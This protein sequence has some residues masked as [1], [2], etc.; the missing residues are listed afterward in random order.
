MLAVELDSCWLFR[1]TVGWHVGTVVA[2][3]GA[4]LLIGENHELLVGRK[5]DIRKDLGLRGTTLAIR[6][7][8]RERV[9]EAAIKM[10]IVVS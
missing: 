2:A 9:A 10:L 5:G 6:A 7:S 4:T 3:V 1:L 8:I